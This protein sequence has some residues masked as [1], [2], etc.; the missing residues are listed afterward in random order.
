MGEIIKIFLPL[1]YGTFEILLMHR[2]ID[3]LSWQNVAKFLLDA[4]FVALGNVN[5]KKWGSFQLECLSIFD[6]VMYFSIVLF[7]R[8]PRMIAIF[9]KTNI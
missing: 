5:H 1:A 9:R 2:I 8:N 4:I 6:V 3:P 7:T